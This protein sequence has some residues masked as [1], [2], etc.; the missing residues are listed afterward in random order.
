ME[1]RGDGAM[2]AAQDGAGAGLGIRR[3]AALALV[4]IP[5]LALLL[6]AGAAQARR[7]HLSRPGWLG[8]TQQELRG[9]AFGHLA[10]GLPAAG[11]LGSIEGVVRDAVKG[12]GVAGVEVCADPV[13]PF[14]GP[15]GEEAAEA[16]PACSLSTAGG[17]YVI[18][19]LPAG[20]YA[21]EFS[22][23]FNG[24]LDYIRQYYD[25]A[26]TFEES[27][28]IVLAAGKRVAGIDAELSKGGEVSGLVTRASGGTPLA[29]I[30][31]CAW[32]VLSRVS[33][34][35]ESNSAG[36]Y[37][38]TGLPNG[39]FKVG[40][41]ASPGRGMNYLTQFYDDATSYTTA[42]AIPMKVLERKEGIDA[43]LQPGA[44]I[45]G[46]VT[47]GESGAPAAGTPVCAFSSTEEEAGGCELTG[48]SGN[49]TIAGLPTGSYTVAFIT[50]RSIEYFNQVFSESEATPVSVSAPEGDALHVNAVLPASPKRII[51]PRVTGNATVGGTLDCEEGTY[52][53]VP[54]PTLAVEWLRDG[55]A[56]TGATSPVYVVQAADA[57]HQLQCK[58]TATNVIGYVWVKTAGVLIS[59]PAPIAAAQS[60]TP[61]APA[62]GVLSSVAVVPVLTAASR[63]V[64]SR[65][66]TTVRLKCSGG[67]CHGTVQLLLR[68]VSH[69]HV[70]MLLLATGSFSLQAGTSS[71]VILH[72]TAAGRSHLA[73]DAHRPVAARLKLS[74]SGG[75]STT[76][77]VTAS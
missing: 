59:A 14:E 15:E 17:D 55:V 35:A 43:A 1:K 68:V 21:V 18:S 11:S 27:T 13:G 62:G 24:T 53:G 29:G 65:H 5:A 46:T 9:K 64:G 51:A 48:S 50:E 61:S 45:A 71:D 42:T 2:W 40:F 44:E 77:A 66:R 47:S 60:A 73:H 33:A 6:C 38:I 74:L 25:E 39:S 30:E 12:T 54:A 75:A 19:G 32:G 76:H 23:P 72:L 7:A 8:L 67:P 41:R 69:R 20:E 34:C 56:I 70:R 16:E 52:S 22:T 57:G 26:K 37:L 28:V 10:A 36:H 58:V 3:R 63:I 31:V 4:V 49:Y